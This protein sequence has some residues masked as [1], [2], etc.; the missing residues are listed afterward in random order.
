MLP[1]AAK[2]VAPKIEEL[3]KLCPVEIILW[4]TA[5]RLSLMLLVNWLLFTSDG[6]LMLL[7]EFRRCKMFCVEF[8][9][10]CALARALFA[11][12]RRF[13]ALFW[14]LLITPFKNGMATAPPIM[15]PNPKIM[16]RRLVNKAILRVANLI[17]CPKRI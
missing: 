5:V 7:M 6:R 1:T 2:A 12:E 14:R 17:T 10:F 4:P 11:C 3:D 16:Q 8:T 9:A 15:I 13:V